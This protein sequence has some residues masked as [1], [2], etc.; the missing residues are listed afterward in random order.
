[1]AKRNRDDDGFDGE[2]EE[3]DSKVDGNNTVNKPASRPSRSSRKVVSYSE[4]DEDD[5]ENE[6]YDDDN[7]ESDFDDGADSNNEDGDG[8][9]AG[10]DEES[11]EDNLDSDL[12][13][14]EMEKGGKS[15]TAKKSTKKKVESSKTS[16]KKK[17]KDIDSTQM[18]SEDEEDEKKSKTVKKKK[19]ATPKNLTKRA[20][21]NAGG[22]IGEA[23]YNYMKEQNRPYSIQN[24]VD[25]LHNAY[26]KK[27]VTD[28]MERLASDGKLLCKEYGKQKVYLI[29]QADCK[30][31]NKEEMEVLDQNITKSETELADLETKLK[32]LKHETR[33]TK[34]TQHLSLIHI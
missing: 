24:V 34:H 16:T 7:F 29:D 10:L 33:N 22:N 2:N 1:M 15:K 4:Y 17:A 18:G 23:V 31:L 27:Q 30:E 21:A 19:L 20:V 13:D 3:Q 5:D 25:N 12:E 11:E 28:E 26:S 6:D 14:E 32:A 8:E 9:D